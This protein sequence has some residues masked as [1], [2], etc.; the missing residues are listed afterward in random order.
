MHNIYEELVTMHKVV[1]HLHD[2]K[3]N[4]K[5][6][7]KTLRVVQSSIVSVHECLMWYK[8]GILELRKKTK[9]AEL[10]KEKVQMLSQI[11]KQLASF[12]TRIQGSYE[13]LYNNVD[14]L[15]NS[16]K[17]PSTGSLTKTKCRNQFKQEIDEYLE[18]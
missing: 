18:Q 7:M 1:V 5:Y 10:E 16:Y 15:V 12:I 14:F 11:K 8:G 6:Y 17:I 4:C 9:E 13:R 3:H 2:L